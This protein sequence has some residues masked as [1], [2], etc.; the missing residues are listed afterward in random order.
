LYF[1]C[2]SIVGAALELYF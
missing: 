2:E 1:Y